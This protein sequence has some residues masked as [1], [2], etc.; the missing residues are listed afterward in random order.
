MLRFLQYSLAHGR[1]IRA[2]L[3]MDGAMVQK[4]VTVLSLADGRVTLQLGARKK[5]VELPCAD[6]L[7]CDYARGD[8]GEE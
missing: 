1:A 2:V 3:L 8:H 5:P 4:K 6:I 7:S